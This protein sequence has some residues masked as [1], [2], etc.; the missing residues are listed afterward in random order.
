MPALLT[1]AST[2]NCPHGGTVIEASQHSD[3]SGTPIA[4]Q[5]ATIDNL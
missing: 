3:I 2:M 5:Q 4:G 1:V